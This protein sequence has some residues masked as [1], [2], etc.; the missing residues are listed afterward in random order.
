MSTAQ[1]LSLLIGSWFLGV[2]WGLFWRVI[3]RTWLEWAS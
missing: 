3:T 1:A 2:G